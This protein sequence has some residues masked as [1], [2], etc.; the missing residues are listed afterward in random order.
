MAVAILTDWDYALVLSI[1]DEAR[2]TVLQAIDD[3]R[4]AQVEK[5]GEQ[6]HPDGTN[7]VDFALQSA[8]F[9]ME[10]EAA[11]EHGFLTWR[12]I[13]REEVYEAFAETDPEKLKTELIQVAAV[14]AAWIQDINGRTS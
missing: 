14:A 4:D 10:C 1:G 13:L 9:R 2:I 8:H 11:T 7:D 6:H 5:F 3:E 12:H